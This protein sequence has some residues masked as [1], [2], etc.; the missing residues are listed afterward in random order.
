MPRI[1][2][3]IHELATYSIFSTFDL[4]SAYYQIS[5]ADEDKLYTEFIADGKLFQFC[6]MLFGLTNDV[7]LFQRI[8]ND[9]DTYPSHKKI[10]WTD[11]SINTYVIY[12]KSTRIVH[13]GWE[14]I[15]QLKNLKWLKCIQILHHG[16]R[17]F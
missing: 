17:T 5:I 3:I 7:A 11:R 14:K 16:W 12:L 4:K 2:Y 8:M 10:R 1:D 9:M 6:R 13:H 15:L